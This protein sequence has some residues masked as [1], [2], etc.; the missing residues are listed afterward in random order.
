MSSLHWIFQRVIAPRGADPATGGSSCFWVMIV[1]VHA[2]R[3]AARSA[4]QL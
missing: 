1:A 3:A 2:A 4:S